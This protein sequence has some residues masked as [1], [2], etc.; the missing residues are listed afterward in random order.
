MQNRKVTPGR[1]RTPMEP[2][3]T[4]KTHG[5]LVIEQLGVHWPKSRGYMHLDTV[6]TM[7][8][9]DLVTLFPPGDQRGAHLG[10]P[11]GGR[12]TWSPDHRLFAAPRGPPGAAAEP[13][14]VGHGVLHAEFYA[15]R[16]V[17]GEYE[18]GGRPQGGV[19]G[20]SVSRWVCSY[21]TATA[22]LR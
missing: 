14:H 6:I 21:H 18:R 11:A 1:V 12:W 20:E 13:L 19:L 22:T 9:R 2:L 15:F 10:D 5:P 3:R 8:D 4:L 17:L 7:D 16:Q